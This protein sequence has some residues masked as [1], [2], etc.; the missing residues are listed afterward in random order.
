MTL[1]RLLSEIVLS[2]S[3]TI[4]PAPPPAPPVSPAP[5]E[6]AVIEALAPEGAPTPPGANEGPQKRNQDIW[7]RL[8][9][10]ESGMTQMQG[11]KY[12]GFFS[13]LP[14]TGR[15]VGLTGLPS[16]HSYERQ[17]EAAQEIVRRWGWATQF[18]AC[19][20]KLGLR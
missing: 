20:R 10:C 4:L 19:S 9:R 6:P 1:G 7:E 17:K 13:M 5:S 18:P 11:P 8:A 15:A 12:Y 16:D 2:L 14:S 3:L